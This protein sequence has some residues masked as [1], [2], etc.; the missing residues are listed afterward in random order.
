MLLL[1][2]VILEMVCE[3]EGFNLV[4]IAGGSIVDDVLTLFRS[5]LKLE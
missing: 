4:R 3:L 2:D 5:H 1:V